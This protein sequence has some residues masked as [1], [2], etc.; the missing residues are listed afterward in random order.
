MLRCPPAATPSGDEGV[1]RL[2]EERNLITGAEGILDGPS[3]PP[4]H[5]DLDFIDQTALDWERR[6]LEREPK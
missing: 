1:K 4:Q 2:V 6:L 3:G 5:D